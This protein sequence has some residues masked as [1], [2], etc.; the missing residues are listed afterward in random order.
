MRLATTVMLGIVLMLLAACGTDE[1]PGATDTSS[2]S[3]SPTVTTFDEPEWTITIPSGWTREDWTSNADAKKAV[4]YKDGDGNYVIV[5]IDP[6]G[7]DFN[8]D[9]TWRYRVQGSAFEVVSKDPCKPNPD[10]PCPSNDT[11]FDVYVVW[12]SGADAPKVG[13]HV[14]Y[15]TLG[16]LNRTSID[17]A[18]FEQVIESLRVKG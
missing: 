6:E 4:R 2:P 9:E 7:S 10:N 12:P 17:T 1:T 16:N 15:F 8:P 5:A 13:G 11:R 18:L 14:W 3:P